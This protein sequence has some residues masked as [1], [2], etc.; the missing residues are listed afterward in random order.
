MAYYDSRSR[1]LERDD[2]LCGYLYTCASPD[3]PSRHRDRKDRMQVT[4]GML[5]R[6]VSGPASVFEQQHAATPLLGSLM[7]KP[8]NV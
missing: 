6:R 5:T 7:Q 4:I 2:V 8:K 3:W 1:P